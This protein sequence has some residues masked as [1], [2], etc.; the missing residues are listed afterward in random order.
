MWTL[1]TTYPGNMFRTH[2]CNSA[3]MFLLVECI[4]QNMRKEIVSFPICVLG[5]C[6]PLLPC[7]R[8]VVDKLRV[9]RLW[10][11]SSRCVISILS[12]TSSSSADNY[13]HVGLLSYVTRAQIGFR[14]LRFQRDIFLLLLLAFIFFSLRRP[15]SCFRQ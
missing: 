7:T 8:R 9:L 5:S 11:S 2:V 6:L 13:G 12:Q 14:M 10:R 15:F 1:K 3:K 4:R